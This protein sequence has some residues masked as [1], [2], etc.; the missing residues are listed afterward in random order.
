MDALEKLR[1]L[2]QRDRKL[3]VW[4][5]LVGLLVMAGSAFFLIR[6]FNWSTTVVY[7]LIGSAVVGLLTFILG[8]IPGKATKSEMQQD[9]LSAFMQ[10]KV[11]EKEDDDSALPE[12]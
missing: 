7:I 4:M 2:R 9:A 11:R 12:S 3:R 6:D 10:E 1:H 5:R 8:W